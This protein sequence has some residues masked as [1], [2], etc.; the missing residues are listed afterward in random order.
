MENLYTTISAH[1]PT[2]KL[3]CASK[4]VKAAG[5]I[6]GLMLTINLG[7]K[8]VIYPKQWEEV[9][10][11]CLSTSMSTEQLSWRNSTT[12]NIEQFTS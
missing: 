2:L 8:L 10:F 6:R 12:N 4:C 3:S 5:K 9:N 7:L 11:F 1:L